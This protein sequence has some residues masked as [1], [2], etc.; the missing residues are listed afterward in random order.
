MTL[1]REANSLPDGDERAASFAMLTLLAR[2]LVA[3]SVPVACRL[4][5]PEAIGDGAR[6]ADDLAAA[7]GADTGALR[8]LL[9]ALAVLGAVSRDGDRYSLTALGRTLLPGRYSLAE[10]ARF[11]GD[12]FY[13]RA[14]EALDDA[15]TDGQSA[16]RHAHGAG[17]FDYI[18]EHPDALA[19]FQGWMTRQSALQTPAVLAAY[20]FGG[21]GTI[22]DV[23]GGHGTLLAAILA[24][25][26]AARGILYDAPGV[27]ADA[28]PVLAPVADRSEIVSGDFFSAVPRGGDTYV[29]KHIVHDWDDERA[30]RILR[31]VRA[32]VPD[33]GRVVVVDTVLPDEDVYTHGFFLDLTMLVMTD[34]GR[35][36]TAGEFAALLGDAGLSL[37][38]IVPT[39]S[40]V[41]VIE[42]VPA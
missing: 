9:R 7:L 3:R 27:V 29:L 40:P 33:T 23:G 37:S 14:W 13:L 31:N 2:S 22:V 36:R 30:L 21:A 11:F 19:T 8:R 42:A 6:T 4:G 39:E 10:A 18:G 25:Q 5:I 32:V 38:R 41:S 26:P 35:E 28:S 1:E 34:G 17:L 12:P 15:V 20:D 24:A 16:F